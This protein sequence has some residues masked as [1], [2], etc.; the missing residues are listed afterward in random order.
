MFTSLGAAAV[1]GRLRSRVL[2][3]Y[4]YGPGGPSEVFM[5]RGILVPCRPLPGESDWP[6]RRL[7]LSGSVGSHLRHGWTRTPPKAAR[8]WRTI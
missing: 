6:L 2:H 8:P 1:P 3:F 7:T 4:I 5:R